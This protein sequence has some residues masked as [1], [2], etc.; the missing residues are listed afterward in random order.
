MTALSIRHMNFTLQTMEH[1]EAQKQAEWYAS[2]S[3]AEKANK[4]HYW[5]IERK[6]R[7]KKN[8]KVN[9]IFVRDLQATKKEAAEIFCKHFRNSDV[10]HRL[11]HL[12]AY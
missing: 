12:L 5:W 4:S 8:G 6:A 10:K 2:L 3:A 11:R 1:I 9:W 7:R